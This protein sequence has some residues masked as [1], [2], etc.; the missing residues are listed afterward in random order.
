MCQGTSALG[1]IL[2]L[3]KTG[4]GVG[5]L[6]FSPDGEYLIS[7][8]GRDGRLLR[9]EVNPEAWAERACA[10]AKRNLSQAE[11]GR[12][13]GDEPYQPTCSENSTPLSPPL[14]FSQ[15]HTLLADLNALPTEG[16]TPTLIVEEFEDTDGL[17]SLPRTID[18][19]VTVET[20]YV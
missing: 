17:D 7:G 20:W 5:A 13:F 14:A 2:K 1:P 3:N 19:T 12:Y 9:W 6:A 18:I 4:V 11:W 10:S 8:G 16:D 15:T